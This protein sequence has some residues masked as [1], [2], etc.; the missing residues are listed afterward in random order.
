MNSIFKKLIILLT[1]LLSTQQAFCYTLTYDELNKSIQNKLKQQT[2]FNDCTIKVSGI[3]YEKIITQDA[4]APKIEIISQNQTFQ[5]NSFK[6]VV[7]K[8]SKNNII[9]AFSINVQTLVYQNVLVAKTQ[10]PFGAELSASNTAIERKEVSRFL[11]KTLSTLEYGSIASRNYPKDSIIVSNGIKQKAAMLK[12]STIDIIFLS[13][14]GL[15]IT[16]QGK[17]LKDGAV[18]ETIL[19]KS[20]KYNKTYNATVNSSRQAT[21]RI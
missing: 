10:I 21:V 9:K 4:T 19:V 3:P 13:Q 6:R 14:K 16:V 18:G 1:L 15:R 12:N 5:P 20:D 7:V 2:N 17:A 8:D 11:D